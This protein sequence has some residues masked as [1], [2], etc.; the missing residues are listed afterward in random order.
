MD[1]LFPLG[2]AHYLAGGLIIGLGVALLFL[3]TGLIGGTSSVFTTTWSYLSR[4]P[5]FSQPRFLG[6][7]EWRLVYA[8]GMILGAAIWWLAAGR[9]SGYVMGIPWWQLAV[10]GFIAG[11]GARMSNGCTSGHGI[12]GMGSL[13]L[14][15]MLAVL[16]F[17]A[18][19]M[20]TARL[21]LMVGG[22]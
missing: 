10:G 17:L 12:C 15:S 6:T 18:T 21:V 7:R 20:I 19:A 11:F 13:Q 8:A 2:I 3:A 16:T 5:F 9:D 14:P 1:A 4:L 22:K